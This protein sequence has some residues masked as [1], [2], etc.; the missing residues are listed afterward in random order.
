MDGACRA[1]G[2]LLGRGFL[3]GI[4]SVGG[5]SFTAQCSASE[6][7]G[8]SE[9]WRE[10]G[11]IESGPWPTSERSKPR[12]S[13]RDQTGCGRVCPYSVLT[14]ELMANTAGGI[15]TGSALEGVLNFGVDIE[16]NRRRAEP[17]TI[18]H[19]GALGIFGDV[20]SEKFVGSFNPVSN[21][22]GFS[23]LRLFQA[24]VQKE[25]REGALA[26]R[27]G[28][29]ALDDH[30]M[31]SGN[32]A[33][34]M[35][36]VFGP[37]PTESGNLDAPNFPLGAPGLWG[38]IRRE[39]KG[40]LQFGIYSGDAGEEAINDHG[41]EFGLGGSRG[42][43]IGI[44]AGFEREF[45]G[46]PGSYKFGSFYHTG[47]FVNFLS[48]ARVEGNSSLY[49]M[50]DQVLFLESDSAQGLSSF[51][52]IG[53]TPQ[54]KRN[55]VTFYSDFGLTYRGF[56][57]NRDSDLLGVAYS[58]TQFGDAF[59]GSAVASGLRPRAERVIE[60]T[61]KIALSQ[62]LILQPDLQV[63]LDPYNSWKDVFLVGMR[64]EVTY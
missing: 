43:A 62:R 11:S 39:D 12:I 40:Y 23:T 4:L 24:W 52:R 59:L 13:S 14:G 60:L 35:N 9:G 51:F 55:K 2:C 30:F 38:S 22:A 5:F 36:S 8:E 28:Q 26:I 3:A 31:V 63:V 56:L 57:P 20:P 45:R 15:R 42:Y 19:I 10:I 54:G 48:D 44:E 50:F 33:L 25:W 64:V 7:V 16:L 61:C 53:G 29:I 34:F 17:G 46:M 58:T 37:M 47:D 41:L 1:L 27:V 18:F 21:I 6:S 49:F 32:A